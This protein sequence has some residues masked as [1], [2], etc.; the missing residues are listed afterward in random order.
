MFNYFVERD[1]KSIRLGKRQSE[2]EDDE[3]PDMDE[4]KILKTFKFTSDRKCSSTV[5]RAPDGNVYVYVKGSEIA[6]K[7]MLKEGQENQ[8]KDAEADDDSFAR[9]GLRTLYFGYK[10]LD[11]P[12]NIS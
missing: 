6:V 9:E 10:L 4:Y 12:Q 1:S 8:L 7:A 5:V 2:P 3:Q 11:T